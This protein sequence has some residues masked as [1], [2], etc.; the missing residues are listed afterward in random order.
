MIGRSRD[1][2]SRGAAALFFVIALVIAVSASAVMLRGRMSALVGELRTDRGRVAALWVAE[3]GL[4]HAR[5]ALDRDRSYTGGSIEVGRGTA[6]ISVR[7]E[8]RDPDVV[9]VVVRA[10]VDQG[11]GGVARRRVEARLRL[12]AGLPAIEEWSASR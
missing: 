5:W 7:R 8:G 11:A 3:G 4:E 2:R 9:Q 6:R 12:G 10:R 1:G